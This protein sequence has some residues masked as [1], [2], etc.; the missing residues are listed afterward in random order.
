MP[1]LVQPG[2]WGPS[3]KF[4]KRGTMRAL[5]WAD[6]PLS[7]FSALAVNTTRYLATE[8]SAFNE[9][10]LHLLQRDSFFVLPRPGDQ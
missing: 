4:S 10:R 3:A 6:S 2:G 9:V 7:T 8:F 5:I 1:M